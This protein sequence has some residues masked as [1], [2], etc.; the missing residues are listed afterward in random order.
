M[1]SKSRFFTI[2]TMLA[3][4][5]V[6]FTGLVFAQEDKGAVPA[7]AAE[8]TNSKYQLEA[9]NGEAVSLTE[10]ANY[11][12][13]LSDPAVAS[14]KGGI[15]GLAATNPSTLGNNR[16]QN[17]AA[18]KAYV[19][20]LKG[21]Q[22][23]FLS[24]VNGA[25]GRDVK[26]LFTYQHAFNGMALVITPLEADQ[27]AK[28]D[29]VRMVVRET[30][31]QPLTDVGPAWI[32][33]TGVWDGSGAPAG[34]STM[35]EGVVVA[36][37]D[38]GINST[39][40]SFADLGED[41]Y[42]H[43]NPLG[44]G[45]YLGVCDPTNPDY[46]PAFV[47]N[48]KLIGVHD[49]IDGDGNDPNSPEDGD[50]HGSHTASTV[51][52]NVVTATL[53]APTAAITDTISGVAPHANIIA[54]DVCRN[55]ESSEGGGCPGTALLAAVNQVV[56]DTLEL[57]NGIAAI[58]YSISGG[59][60]PYADP[61]EL[62]F[63]AAT[64]AGVFVS[65]SAGNE[66]PGA[67]TVAHVSPWVASV[68]AS[69]HNRT[70]FNDVVSM[71]SDGG[72]LADIRGVGFTSG[73]GP[74]PIVYAGDYP[75]DNG[76]TPE[77][78]GAGAAGSN[79]SPW[80]PGTFS[81]EI[82]ICDRGTYGRVEKGINALAAGAGGMIL[83]DNG[84]GLVLDGHALPATHIS[85]AD[86]AALKA[87]VAANNN[88]MGTITGSILDYSP[89]NADVMAGFSSRGPVGIFDV[90]KP[91][92]TAPGVGIW[93]AVANDGSGPDDY[94]L[95]SG[96]SMSSPHNAG[97][98]AL[99]VALYPSWTPAQIKS[100][101]MM[102]TDTVDN[103][104][105]DGVTPADP[106]DLGAGRINVSD[107]SS[108]GFVLDETTENFEAADPT[109]NNGSSSALRALN[110]AS[111]SNDN[112]VGGCSWTRTV[113]S[114]LPVAATYTATTSAPVGINVTVTPV[115]FTLAAGATQVL[116]INVD[117]SGAALGDWQFASVMFE[118]DATQPALNAPTTELLNEAFTGE[119]FPPAD[120]SVYKLAGA[121]TATWIRDT[122][123]S[124]SAPASARRIFGGSTDGN[125]DDWLVTPQITLDSGVSALTFAD[126]GQWM[127]DYGYSGVWASTTSCNPA[128]GEFVELAEIDN[129]IETTWRAVPAI[130]LSAFA[131]QTVCLAF[132]YSGD[133]AHTWWIDDVVVNS[134]GAET[135]AVS[136]M[137]MPI[138]V[139]PSAGNLPSMIEVETRRD[140]GSNTYN[141]LQAIEITDSQVTMYGPTEATLDVAMLAKDP[142]NGDPYDNLDDVFYT[143]FTVPANA[144]RMVAQITASEA[145]DADM[146]W[147][148]GTMP[149]AATELGASTTGTAAEYLSADNPPAGDY[150]VLVQNWESS[151]AGNVDA[152]T[153]ATAVVPD[154]ASGL[155]M[156]D[157]PT[158]VPAGDPFSA[159]LSWDL[160]GSMAGDMFYGA[161]DLGTDAANP[162][163]LGRTDINI[164]RLE[165]DVM[166][167]ASTDVAQPGDVVTYTIT[168]AANTGDMPIAYNITDTIPAGLTYV[169]GS[170]TGG[171]TVDGNVLT[172]SGVQ[173]PPVRDYVVSTSLTDPL[174]T[175][176]LAN[177]GKYVNLQA[178][179]FATDS[180]ITGNGYWQDAGYGGA[181][182]AF[183]GDN[184]GT[185]TG[186]AL[187]FNG[188]GF[189]TL[190]IDSVLGGPYASNSALP[191]AALP[192]ALL[193]MIWNSD[194]QIVYDAAT[195]RGVTTGIQL[196]T[197]GIPSAKLL[198]FD[199]LELASDPT[200]TLDFEMVIR[201]AI[202]DAAGSYE[203]VFAYDNLAG[204]F[205]S[206]VPVGTIGVENFAGNR[207]TEYAYDDANLGTLENGMA[208]CFDWIM[209][210]T[211]GAHV[212]TYQ[213]TVD[214]NVTD[215]TVLTNVVEHV[216]DAP[217]T[218]VETSE[219]MVTVS[220]PAY[221]V[222]LAPATDAMTGMAG[223]V[224]TYTLTITNS[225][226]VAD[227]FDFSAG[228]SAW[229]VGL[230]ASVAL[231][232]GESMAVDVTVSIPSDAADGDMDSVTVTATSA[233]DAMATASSTLTTTATVAAPEE[234][235]IY[236]PIIVKP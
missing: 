133:F 171:A 192:N 34:L 108:V 197:G 119:T 211:V 209:P 102:S 144:K 213:A 120:W 78:C 20:Y 169:P 5:A 235:F 62:A 135:A 136:D 196:T 86:G 17:N 84:T 188:D 27:I 29:G 165:D 104:K 129:S 186:T 220:V 90:L 26:V 64:D 184:S 198:E 195:N 45:N 207:G 95:L 8:A 52:G 217:G 218:V 40:P 101:M 48:D 85:Q 178:F 33:A 111:M 159:M 236:L 98:A 22:A 59:T 42:D 231:D 141:D 100:A 74:A 6:V 66:G 127:S 221:G 35:G 87:W 214:D 152:I 23:S 222:E 109:L 154:T 47:C 51:A 179:G 130:D 110:I 38:T 162:D 128:D 210:T 79:T 68:G 61:V 206:G 3:L 180:G 54:Y 9:V 148:S 107:A 227:T 63:L 113:K 224:V 21:V 49:F 170:V 50:G 137:H 53:Y 175:M 228:A 157:M 96:T 7:P 55:G 88:T 115:T 71:T 73:Y 118:T 177:S 91:D 13:Q 121:G 12:V 41:G 99:M 149:S 160:A 183:Y 39:H 116:N 117:V 16:L 65:T 156:F 139:I 123:Q 164:A 167:V 153:L 72:S 92:V 19:D 143:T 44:S 18:T 163:N 150:W 234:F 190:D 166:K 194:L 105:E 189:V 176:P 2:L 77:L 106:F 232:A 14:Y 230:P 70:I 185:N 56:S 158:A 172:W 112:C 37:L 168:I 205:A 151:G 201:E 147:G 36:I 122:A 191:N 80:N 11:I 60:N 200:S 145:P 75:A 226:N 124:N 82:V 233:T 199:D 43:T 24:N 223:D 215:G 31:E 187:Y 125:Q 131:D 225:G 182:Y 94:G 202:N 161:M 134:F 132:R 204:Q 81:G 15:Q 140:V 155:A 30:I 203:I 142:T 103:F 89:A 208:I 229:T 181:P 1:K 193:S 97:A 114:V 10:P 32:G 126:R 216:N 138:A 212:I 25:L 76:T 93:A 146:F 46:Q 173:V 58:N 28:L 174:C 219:A 83:A 67:G 57:P 4:V 69:T